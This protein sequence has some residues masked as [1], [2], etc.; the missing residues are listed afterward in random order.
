MDDFDAFVEAA[1]AEGVRKPRGKREQYGKLAKA[2]LADE[3]ET[4]APELIRRVLRQ[5]D[6][7]S[8]GLDAMTEDELMKVVRVGRRVQD[9]LAAIARENRKT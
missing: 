5:L 4:P 8:S 2:I 7:E 1:A 9:I 3:P 6:F